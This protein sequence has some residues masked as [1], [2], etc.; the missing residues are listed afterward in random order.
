MQ[1]IN[2]YRFQLAA[3]PHK[4]IELQIDYH[5]IYLDTPKDNLYSAGGTIKKATVAG[6][7][8]YVGGELDL[9]TKLKVTDFCGMLVG[10]SHFFAGQFLSDTGTS[11]D[12]DYFYVQ[13]TLNF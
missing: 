7:D 13:T 10:Y 1:N 8:G 5:L 4:R 3:S 9:L 2:N 6:A 11:D 12:A